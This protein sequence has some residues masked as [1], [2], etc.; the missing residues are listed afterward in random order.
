MHVADD[1]FLTTEV[2]R[3]FRLAEP[4]AGSLK[5]GARAVSKGRNTQARH[6]T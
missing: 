5:K 6:F 3:P 2:T 4:F 1:K